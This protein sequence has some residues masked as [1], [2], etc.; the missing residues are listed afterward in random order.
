MSARTIW[1]Q[2]GGQVVQ[3]DIVRERFYHVTKKLPRE[4]SINF[5]HKSA[6]LP[7]GYLPAGGETFRSQP[8]GYFYGWTRDMRTRLAS[9]GD[10]HDPLRN[11]FIHFMADTAWEIEVENGQYEV[12]VC[13]GET[14]YGQ[15]RA[16]IYVEG[17]EFCKDLVLPRKETREITRLVA[18]KDGRVTLTSHEDNRVQKA[19]RLNHLRIRRVE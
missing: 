2:D 12:M 4:V 18:V 17:I 3:S 14:V 1:Q 15:E 10:A 19:T 5:Q 9:R 8:S 6:P 16:T 7:D 11:T 13:V